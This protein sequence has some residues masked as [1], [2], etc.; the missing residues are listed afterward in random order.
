[1]SSQ[2]EQ[3]VRITQMAQINESSSVRINKMFS[4]VGCGNGEHSDLASKETII[5]L[6]ALPIPP[7][8][9]VTIAIRSF[10]LIVPPHFNFPF[11][12]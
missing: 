6:A 12:C 4:V 10:S 11:L 8:P 5:E 7:P 9:P 3:V 1:M 2:E